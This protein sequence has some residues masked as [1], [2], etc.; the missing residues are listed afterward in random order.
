MQLCSNELCFQILHLSLKICF[1]RK[2]AHFF[3]ELISIQKLHKKD[4][5]FIDSDSSL[6]HTSQH[7]RAWSE[8]K[9]VCFLC[10][11]IT[12]K[13]IYT[14]TRQRR[15][16]MLHHLTRQSPISL[17]LDMQTTIWLHQHYAKA[18]SSSFYKRFTSHQA[19]VCV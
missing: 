3:M 2:V 9:Q 14:R 18:G 7:I 1:V 16:S 12:Y 8:A 17:K 15:W 5:L 13:K 4:F 6:L 11:Q 19:C 10:D